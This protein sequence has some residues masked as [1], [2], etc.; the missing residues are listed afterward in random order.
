MRYLDIIHKN[1]S[2]QHQ[3]H[4]VELIN[5]KSV[6]DYVQTGLI[7][8]MRACGVPITPLTHYTRLSSAVFEG[9]STV[10]DAGREFLKTFERL[11]QRG[12]MNIVVGAKVAILNIR[13]SQDFA[14]LFGFKNPK[15]ITKIYREPSNNK[16]IQLEFNNDAEDVWPRQPLASYN[17]LLIMSSALFPSA[18]ALEQALTALMLAKPQEISIRTS[19]V[20]NIKRTA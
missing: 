11:D 9:L 19:I 3:F 15:K 4:T 2:T 18:S 6:I 5:K 16:I 10:I 12:N 20:E 13:L 8:E 17:G 14:E 7:P 1:I